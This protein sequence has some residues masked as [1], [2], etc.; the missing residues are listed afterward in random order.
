MHGDEST[1]GQE[2]ATGRCY[3]P[4][5]DTVSC[6]HCEEPLEYVVVLEDA[7]DR[8]RCPHCNRTITR[9]E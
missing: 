6:P 7:M 4:G 1:V 9:V 2:S 5:E 8:A 3:Y